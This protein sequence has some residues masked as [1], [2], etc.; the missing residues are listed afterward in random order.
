[1]LCWSVGDIR[2]L[3]LGIHNMQQQ[4]INPR[5]ACVSEGYISWF[6]CVCVCVRSKFGST[7]TRIHNECKA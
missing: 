5:C 7:Y 2:K 4:L 1:M 6:E 3:M